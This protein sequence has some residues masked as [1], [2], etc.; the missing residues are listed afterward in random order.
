M[1]DEI[2]TSKANIPNLHFQAASTAIMIDE[3]NKLNLPEEI[4]KDLIKQYSDILCKL[5]THS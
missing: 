1:T 4:K 5:P 3:A 2:Q